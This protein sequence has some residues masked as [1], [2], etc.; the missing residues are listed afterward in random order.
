MGTLLNFC[1][2]SDILINAV[3]CI[4][5]WIINRAYQRGRDT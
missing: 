5:Y 4:D 3:L 1:I 2:D